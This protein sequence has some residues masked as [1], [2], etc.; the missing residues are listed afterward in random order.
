MRAV[1]RMLVAAVAAMLVVT[2]VSAASRP[3]DGP[4]QLAGL[5]DSTAPKSGY[6]FRT[7]AARVREVV[8][9]LGFSRIDI[10]A[11]DIGSSTT[12]RY[13]RDFPDEVRKLFVSETMLPGFGAEQDYGNAWHYRFLQSPEPV[14]EDIVD[15][16][17]VPAFYNYFYDGAAHHPE[18]LAKDEFLA[19]QSDP[20]ERHAANWIPEENPGFVVDCAR[21][22]FGDEPYDP[23][24]VPTQQ[25]TCTP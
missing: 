3:A 5:G 7:T 8:H 23:A 4:P 11:H 13:P 17:D 22:F 10:L 6:D 24:V 15:D 9:S 14:P 19:Q 20:A 21:L 25:K 1:A 18:R 2:T 16:E 12:Y